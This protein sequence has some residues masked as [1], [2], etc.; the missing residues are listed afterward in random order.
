MKF[1]QQ[2]LEGD[3]RKARMNFDDPNPDNLPGP[4]RVCALTLGQIRGFKEHLPLVAV[5]CNKGLRARHW[6][7]LNKIAGFDITPNAGTRYIYYLS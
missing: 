5:L 3:P 1:K 7:M 2:A 4:L 6:L